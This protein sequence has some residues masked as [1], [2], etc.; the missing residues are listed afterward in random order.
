MT[1]SDILL[2]S[3]QQEGVDVVFG[4][5]GGQIIGTYDRLYDY[6]IKHVLPRHE[7]GAVHAAEGYA[8]VTGKPGVCIAT[9]GPGATNL[10]TGIADAYMDSIPLVIITGQVASHLIGSDAF[11]E[12]DIVGITRP[13][14]KH[15]YLIKDVKDIAPAVKEAF[16][17]AKSGRP[18]PVLIDMPKDIQ[19]AKGSFDYPTTIDLQG[20]QPSYEGH[21]MQIKKVLHA[22]SEAKRPLMLVGGGV[23]LGNASQELLKFAEATGIPVS[24]TFMGQGA[25]PSG[26]PLYVGWMGMHGNYAS[27][28]AS[29]NAD[30][31]LA[32]GTRF[33]DRTTGNFGMFA[34]NA[35]IAQI[36]V[37]PTSIG[38]NIAVKTPIVGDVKSVLGQFLKYIKEYKRDK[39]AEDRAKWLAD[40]AKWDKE[41]PFSYENSNKVI[42]PQYV[43]ESIYNIT[44]GD[45]V[46]TTEVGQH[47][48]FAGQFY[49]FKRP[50][51]FISSGGLG[52]MGFGLPA[53]VGAK[54]GAPDRDVFDISGDG[55]FMMNVQELA[56]AVQY[57]LGIKV[58]ILNNQFLGMVR[59]WQQLFFDK[60]YSYTCMEVQPDFVKLAEAFGCVGLRAETPAEVMPVLIEAMKVKDRPVV[61]DFRCVR[62][63]NVFPIVP[64]GM[65]LDKMIFK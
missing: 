33:S 2:K 62:E 59:Q 44:K 12:A 32:I 58:A 11:Q 51:Q 18:G 49:K 7:Q 48:F 42:K 23:R 54:I 13:I 55:S 25:F 35:T 27:N 9:S 45:A 24:M 34:P 63:E 20:Y 28:Q 64:P 30:Y 57:R 26:N 47:Q 56:T 40:I 29:I 3:L 39:H 60:R 43:I 36:D 41:H 1:G 10:V 31:I 14:V 53:A 37:D 38:K 50:E 65:G 4:Y 22:L 8:R 46:I 21:P 16:H 17:I 52:T 5:P 15:S 61:M 19:A 6:D